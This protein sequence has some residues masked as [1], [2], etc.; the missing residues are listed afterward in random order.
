M[1]VVGLTG[2]IGSGKTTV[3]KL[4]AQ[5]GIPIIDADKVARE[6]TTAKSSAFQQIVTY[7]YEKIT[8][9]NG[10]LDRSKL[11]EIIFSNPKQRLWLEN[12]LHPL[13]RKEMEKQIKKLSSPYCLAIIPL[14]L[15]VEFYSFINRILV[16][17][18]AEHLQIK[19]VNARDQIPLSQIEAI[20]KT[21]AKRQDRVNKAQDIITN[22]G[23][24]DDLI[25]QVDKL[26]KKYL[27]ISGT[28]FRP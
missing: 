5:H 21:Q 11:R 24:L 19:R 22:N 9:A 10:E 7:F 18:T 1:L 16:I 2:G 20:L 8:L 4:F 6:I 12:L 23:K 14:L 28:H 27:E 26:H 17:D 15:E 13:I 25:P 3:A